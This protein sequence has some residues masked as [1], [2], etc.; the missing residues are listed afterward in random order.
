MSTI[1]AILIGVIIGL[2]AGFTLAT[3]LLR[4]QIGDKITYAIEKLRAKKGGVI[5]VNQDNTGSEPQIN[6]KKERKK[7]FPRKT[8]N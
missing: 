8:K 3:L 1:T 2:C 4:K 6:K 5:D 7:L